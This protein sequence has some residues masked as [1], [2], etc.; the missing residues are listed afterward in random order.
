MRSGSIAAR[1]SD[2]QESRE[3]CHVRWRACCACVFFGI[4]TPPSLAGRMRS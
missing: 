1:D 2:A 4:P 3:G